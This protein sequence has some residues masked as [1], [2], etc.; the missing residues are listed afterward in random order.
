LILED[1]KLG[2]LNAP[3]QLA[4]QVVEGGSQVI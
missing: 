1:R 3:A 4:D 2:L